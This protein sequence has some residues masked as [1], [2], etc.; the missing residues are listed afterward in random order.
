MRQ[1]R[2]YEEIVRRR[3]MRRYWLKCAMV[4]GI[5]ISTYAI[6][7]SIAT[8]GFHDYQLNLTILII[9]LIGIKLTLYSE[10]CFLRLEGPGNRIV[11]D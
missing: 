5:A 1:K 7:V 4:I 10:L 9:F 8:S 6:V 11:I 3:E 2:F